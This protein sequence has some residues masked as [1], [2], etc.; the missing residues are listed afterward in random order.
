[1]SRP[2]NYAYHGRALRGPSDDLRVPSL[3]SLLID[4][5]A[6]GCARQATSGSHRPSPVST[7]PQSMATSSVENSWSPWVVSILTMRLP[8]MAKSSS[9]PH[10]AARP[11]W[12][13]RCARRMKRTGTLQPRSGRSTRLPNHSER[14][15]SA[16]HLPP[17]ATPHH[18]MRCP[19][20]PR[21]PPLRSPRRQV[22][23][24]QNVRH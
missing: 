13:T 7:C 3:C 14:R 23:L 17:L 5:S 19:T 9:R 8:S 1:M 10:A 16:S 4:P 21:P 12:T 11:M 15:S 22:E 18:V 2:S 6:A 20:G 24:V